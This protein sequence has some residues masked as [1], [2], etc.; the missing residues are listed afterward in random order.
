MRLK[1]W[2]CAVAGAKCRVGLLPLIPGRP[3]LV[4]PGLPRLGDGCVNGGGPLP[5]P[6][7]DSPVVPTHP[8]PPNKVVFVPKAPPGR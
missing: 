6:G 2:D 7:G 8:G 1:V 5:Q 3:G 4:F